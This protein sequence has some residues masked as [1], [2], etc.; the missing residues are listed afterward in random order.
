MAWRLQDIRLGTRLIILLFLAIIVSSAGV[1]IFLIQSGQRSERVVAFHLAQGI[2]GAESEN[3][4]GFIG[5]VE[6]VLT[7]V[8]LFPHFAD[9]QPDLQRDVLHNLL[10][11]FSYL[12]RLAI[13]DETGESL[14]LA[15]S[16]T[17]AW[18]PPSA[19]TSQA[20]KTAIAG[21]M[22]VSDVHYAAGKQPVILIM[23]PIAPP[24]GRPV[25]TIAA[26]VG[27]GPL[28]SILEDV[29]L[30]QESAVYIV[31]SRGQ[32]IAHSELGRQVV[33][34]SFL[35][36]PV[37]RSAVAGRPDTAFTKEDIYT[38]PNGNR[39]V[40]TYRQL[41]ETGWSIIIQQPE[42]VVFGPNYRMVGFAL[43]WTILFA[44]L[45]GLLGLYLIR[46]IEE[47]HDIAVKSERE[48]QTLYRVSQ[49]LASTLD[50][51]E[52]LA[53]IAESLANLC[54]TSKSAIWTIERNTLIPTVSLGL[55]PDEETVFRRTEIHMEELSEA[56]RNAITT[57][58]PICLEDAQT[59][60]FPYREFAVRLHIRSALALPINLE[61]EPTGLAITYNPDEVRTFTDDQVRLAQ[62]LASQ[63]A[64]AIEN[65]RA[66]ERER[67]IAE[68]LQRALLPTVPPSIDDF[69]IADKYAAASSE[70]VIGGDF[71]DMFEITSD[72][73]GIVIAD[74]S[75]KGLSAGVHTAM[76]KYMLRAYA[77]DNP[78]PVM[79]VS[80]L[81]NAVY[82]LSGK[83]MF[84]T[85]FYGMLDIVKKEMIYVNAGHELPLLYG[86]DRKMCTRLATTGTAL[87]IVED[88][89][90]EMEK[91]DFLP[92]DVLLFYTDGATD[93]RRDGEF[94]G[95]EGLESMFCSAV[96]GD[97]HQI[98]D[99][100]DRGVREYAEGFLRDDIAL[101][102]LKYRRHPRHVKQS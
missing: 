19:V 59:G 66:Y 94:L 69:E 47:E 17:A 9:L 52:R 12:Q 76:V 26:I 68:T 11:Q 61:H 46:R 96:S 32:V 13:R 81:N 6:T 35:K 20:F 30:V 43:L 49:T 25:G 57:G 54:E 16:G 85:L 23:V 3:V 98:V 53:V 73:V 84:I 27:L 36:Y 10:A 28:Q 60:E 100:M 5:D 80:K 2:L 63:A 21:K 75:G 31:D 90:F 18:M 15:R 101:L 95:I 14:A 64:M 71:Y 79:L 7:S 48:A 50:L 83:E 65:V 44:L 89:K 40:G 29:H 56:A 41:P 87:G 67:R 33:G 62:A 38:D 8:S 55:S 22:F 34:R 93:A 24:G 86:E 72:K 74:V 1:A 39:V 99:D 70:A 58:K 91:I 45:F 78:D 77:V 37:V 42:S 97:A 102:V 92:G 82:K 51:E 88:Y 4:D